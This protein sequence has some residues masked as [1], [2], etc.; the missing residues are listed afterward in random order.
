MLVSQM[1]GSV[2]MRKVLV[3][4]GIADRD[5]LTLV[6]ILDVKDHS[7]PTVCV[8]FSSSGSLFASA[9]YDK[10]VVLY[11]RN[12]VDYFV[13]IATVQFST[14]PE[15]IA[16]SPR[17]FR[18]TLDDS[19]VIAELYNCPDNQKMTVEPVSSEETGFMAATSDDACAEELIIALREVSYLIYFDCQLY[20]T[21]KVS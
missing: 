16:F 21:R 14:S 11:R 15:S 7:K 2:A 19:S 13:K 12:A 1:D 17:F 20:S 8:K 4:P 9:S 10:S 6:S 5:A 3:E 18:G